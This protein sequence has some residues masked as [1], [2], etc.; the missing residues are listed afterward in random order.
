MKSRSRQKPTVIRIPPPMVHVDVVIPIYGKLD[1]F[2]K[3]LECL[4]TAFKS[5]PAWN[6]ERSVSY[7]VLALDNGSPDPGAKAIATSYPGH[8]RFER[9]K[10]NVG[11]PKGCNL[12][13]KWGNAPLI[14][15]LNTDCF[16]EPGAGLILAEEMDNNP[17]YGVIGPKL[18]F[19]EDTPQ[20]PAGRVQHAGI[21]LN[22]RG[23]AVHTFI[24]W[25]ANNPRV[26]KPAEVF[27]ITGAA[28]MT[29]RNIWQE[30]GGFFEGYGVGTWEDV[31]YCLTVRVLKYK[32]RYEPTAVGYHWVGASAIENKVAYPLN[33]NSQIFHYKFQG[34]LFWSEWSRL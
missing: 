9:L 31:D 24:G 22:I 15:F 6:S 14:L 10:E 16:L 32:I 8:I 29:R 11:F 21:D 3:C 33:D 5:P 7:R 27:A 18:L 19:P 4:P 17:D 30:V 34:K 25:T 28:L 20:G 13:S 2:K 1:F 12:A 26:N 23:E